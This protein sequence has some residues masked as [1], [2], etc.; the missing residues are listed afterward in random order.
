[1]RN[2]WKQYVQNRVQEIRKIVPQATWK[3]CP[4]DKNPA[5]LPSRGLTG[6][7]L[8]ESSM[9]WCGPDFLMN[10]QNEWPKA[11]PSQTSDEQAMVEMVKCPSNVT[12]SLLSS[13]DNS[14]MVDIGAVIK[15][16]N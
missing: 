9:W 12:H 7:E 11:S 5:D 1:M 16:K 15:P 2:P 14:T 13:L 6:K 10:P 4:G 8:V 3:H